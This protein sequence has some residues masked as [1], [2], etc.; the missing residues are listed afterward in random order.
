MGPGDP[1]G[2]VSDALERLGRAPAELPRHPLLHGAAGTLLV[3]AVPGAKGPPEWAGVWLT[4]APPVFLIPVEVP[5]RVS[6][7][8]GIDGPAARLIDLFGEAIRRYL[9]EAE[10]LDERVA[11]LQ[12]RG[13]EAPAAEVW[14]LRRDSANL[15]AW[16]ARALVVA[17]EA[18]GPFAGAF[19]GG[20]ERALPSVVQELERVREL[21]AGIQQSLSD[22]I[23][24]RNAEESN[25]IAATANR[26][27]EFSN[28]I[29]VLTNTSNIRM[30]GITY[31]ALL[32]GLVSAVVLI[33][34]TAATILGM[35][36]AAWVPG[37]WVDVVL[38]LLAVIPIVVVFS[39][40]WVHRILAD[41]N[42]TAARSAEGIDDLPENPEPGPSA[43]V[44]RGAPPPGT[45]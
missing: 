14:K 43:G 27:S 44:G 29:A 41:L 25:R 22:L 38:V 15:R 9:E 5:I 36:S 39:R 45:R 30:L 10:R 11:V 20:L 28:R 32:L 13:I 21:A 16:V 3:L 26:L 12:A 18:G 2:S 6:V 37:L 31:V 8:H 33:P 17:G 1:V 35:P 23:L 19:P 4:D 24:M 34:N 7:A 42:A 40:P